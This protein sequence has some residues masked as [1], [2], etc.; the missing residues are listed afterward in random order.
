MKILMLGWEFPPTISGGLGVASQGLAEAMAKK[1][2]DVIFLL[3]KKN[4]AQVSKNL[5]LVDASALSPDIDFWKERKVYTETLA[6]TS[7]GSLLLPYLAP[8]V[9]TQVR[10]VK[11]QKT[12]LKPTQESE[13]LDNIEL[14]GTYDGNLGAEILKYAMLA[15]QVA[16]K[17][18]PE[19]IHAHDWITFRAATM[20]KK[21]FGIPI[22]LHVHSI[23]QDRNGV[24]AQQKVMDEEKMGFDQADHV[25]A[26]SQK[27]KYAIIGAYGIDSSKISVVPNVLDIK[28]TGN[29]SKSPKQI[30][31]I[32]R[33]THQKSPSIF[34]D[35]ARDLCSKGYE[36]NFS[37]IGD[38]YLRSDLENRVASSN[39][40]DRVR[41]YGFLDR[42]ELLKM[43]NTIDLLIVPSASEPFGLVALEA[44]LKGIPV[45]AARGIGLGEFIP[46]IPQVERWDHYSYVQLIERLMTDQEYRQD[47]TETCLKEAKKLTWSKATQATEASYKQAL[48]Q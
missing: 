39:F 5:R 2:N 36:F 41:F 46:S 21:T 34:I 3:P 11:K 24:Y 26:V 40:S 6:E 7:I 16:Q 12:V 22:V 44:I 31:F 38:G 27:L 9:F 20:I 18:K 43:L 37:I 1:G 35:I 48:A 29:Q 32:G 17:E 14:T 10:K 47:I 30:A 28:G 45:A 13:L 25:I 23:E 42:A 19:I 33:L 8:E 15:V 4:D